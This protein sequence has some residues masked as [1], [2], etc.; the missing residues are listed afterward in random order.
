MKI[1]IISDSHDHLENLKK[2]LEKVQDADALIHCGDLVAPFVVKALGEQFTNPIHIIYG[3]NDGDHAMCEEK[4]K[5]FLNIT[6]HG[7]TGT[8]EMGGK[9]IAFVHEPENMQSFLDEDTYDL[10]CYGHTHEVD[11]H[12]EGETLIV[13]PGDVMGLNDQKAHYAIYDT[14]TGKVGLKT[15]DADPA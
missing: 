11:E 8:I 2:V 3:N 9:K 12:M 5:D 13:N 14:A 1:A 7:A 15:I 4:A 6:L 10:I